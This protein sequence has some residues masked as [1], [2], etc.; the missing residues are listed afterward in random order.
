MKLRL[1]NN[2]IR[3]RLTQKETIRFAET[4]RVEEEIEFGIKPSQKIIYALEIDNETQAA[5]A[6]F[7]NNRITVSIPKTQAD[8]WTRTTQIGIEAEQIIGDGKM[9]RLL[10]EKDFAC[11][12]PRKGDD[13]KDGFPHPL[14]GKI[15]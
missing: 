13:D 8:E 9:L 11:L 6:K 5:R 12:E 15:C 4:G 3:L 2:V 14:K 1:K 7:E 10:I